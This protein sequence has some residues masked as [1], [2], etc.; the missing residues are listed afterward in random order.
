[1]V[2]CCSSSNFSDFCFNTEELIRNGEWWLELRFFWKWWKSVTHALTLDWDWDWER[3]RSAMEPQGLAQFCQKAE[4]FVSSLFRIYQA[5]LGSE[6]FQ[7]GRD[8]EV[9]WNSAR[10][11]TISPEVWGVCE[12]LIQNWSGQAWAWVV[13]GWRDLCGNPGSSFGLSPANQN[14]WVR[15]LNGEIT[16]CLIILEIEL[17]PLNYLLLIW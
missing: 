2:G 7:I 16:W 10:T 17:K 11:C 6:L 15:T 4:V 13:S 1:M 5:K 14:R 9:P 12:L 8:L 3:F